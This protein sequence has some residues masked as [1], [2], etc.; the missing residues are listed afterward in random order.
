MLSESEIKTSIKGN[1]NKLEGTVAET[2][3]E[4]A[5]IHIMLSNLESSNRDLMLDFRT[6]SQKIVLLYKISQ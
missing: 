1:V 6:K 4:E 5:R 2:A 3:D